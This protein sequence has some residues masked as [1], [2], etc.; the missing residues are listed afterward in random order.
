MANPPQTQIAVDYEIWE[1]NRPEYP[2]T[3]LAD[4]YQDSDVWPALQREYNT[5][6]SENCDVAPP[7][8][9][10]RSPIHKIKK[11]K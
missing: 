5:E 1:Q 6:K 3:C 7:V 4:I 9:D 10:S 11:I 2:V 8:K